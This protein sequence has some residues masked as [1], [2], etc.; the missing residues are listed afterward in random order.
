MYHKTLP[1]VGNYIHTL[2]QYHHPIMAK[3]EATNYLKG[4]IYITFVDLGGKIFT[5]YQGTSLRLRK[6]VLDS[7]ITEPKAFIFSISS[8]A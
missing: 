2:E 4:Y 1:Q 6:L 5:K 7:G 8:E 3:T